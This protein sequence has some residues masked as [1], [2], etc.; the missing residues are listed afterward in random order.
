MPQQPQHLQV[1][2]HQLQQE[3]LMLLH[4]VNTLQNRLNSTGEQLPELG[5][6]LPGDQPGV[7][8]P[9]APASTPAGGCGVACVPTPALAG[10]G[11]MNPDAMAS[12]QQMMQHSAMAAGAVAVHSSYPTDDDLSRLP[13]VATRVGGSAGGAGVGGWAT[14]GLEAR[15]S[16]LVGLGSGGLGL[17]SGGSGLGALKDELQVSPDGSFTPGQLLEGCMVDTLIADDL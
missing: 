13:P 2:C 8:T 12:Q 7:E 5:I 14:G 15:G 17:G 10:G 9:A 4:R 16:G 3:N 6:C 1:V 11:V